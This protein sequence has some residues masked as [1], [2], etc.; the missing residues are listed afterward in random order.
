MLVLWVFIWA[1]IGI[2]A[3]L[4]GAVPGGTGF[5]VLIILSALLACGFPIPADD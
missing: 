2:C 1:V 3:F 4:A 5:I